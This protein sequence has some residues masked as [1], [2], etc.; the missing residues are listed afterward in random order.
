M[1]YEAVNYSM[2]RAM[3]KVII[4][5]ANHQAAAREAERKLV[6]KHGKAADGKQIAIIGVKALRD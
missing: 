2:G 3:S 5:A 4:E 6:G 1:R